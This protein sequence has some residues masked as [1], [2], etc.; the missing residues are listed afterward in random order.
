MK[1]NVMLIYF[2]ISLD[3][4][5]LDAM[6]FYQKYNRSCIKK[7]NFNSD[8]KKKKFKIKTQLLANYDL[9]KLR[10]ISSTLRVLF[11][12]YIHKNKTCTNS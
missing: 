7:K 3:F 2:V 5:G 8:D 4:G 9:L 12:N 6:K 11:R 1:K 10:K